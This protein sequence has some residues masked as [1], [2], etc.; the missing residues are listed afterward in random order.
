[1]RKP[2]PAMHERAEEL[3]QRMQ[4]DT[5]VKQRQRL[6]ACYLGASGQARYRKDVALWLGVHRH[7]I[8]AWFEAYAQGGLLQ[9]LSYQVSAPPLH[10]RMTDAALTALQAKLTEPQGFAGYDHMRVWLAE[11][12]HVALSYASVQAL[13][14]DTLHAKPQRPRPSHAKKVQK[15]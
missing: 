8:A 12:H 13:V 7:S 4:S 5:D 15:L 11:V 2:L 14:R 1:M 10:R 3:P 9:A 6:H